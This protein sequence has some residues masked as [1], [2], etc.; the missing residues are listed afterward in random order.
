MTGTNFQRWNH[1]KRGEMRGSGHFLSVRANI[2]C[3]KE[4][5]D[6]YEF[7]KEA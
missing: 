6:F 4:R 1:I 7:Q 3:K 5:K 2:K